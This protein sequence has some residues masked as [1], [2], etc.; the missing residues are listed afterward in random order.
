[1]GWVKEYKN[2]K[3]IIILELEKVD[4]MDLSDKTKEKFVS[5]LEAEKNEISRQLFAHESG[6][7]LYYM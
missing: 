4:K 1:M 5:T 7:D 2:R 3:E 6:L